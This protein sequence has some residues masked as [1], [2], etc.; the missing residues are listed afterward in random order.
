M[1]N[2]SLVNVTD[3]YDFPRVEAYRALNDACDGADSSYRNTTYYYDSD[4][5]AYGNSS[6]TLD[7]CFLP[8]SY[9]D[10]SNDCDDFNSSINPLGSEILCDGIDQDCSGA[11]LNG[12]DNDLD[13]YMVEGGYCGLVDCNDTNSSI[14]P[15]A[16]DVPCDGVDQDCSGADL[17]GTDADSDGYMVE[18][19]LCGAV[20][21]NDINV[22]INPDATEIACDG[23][24]QDCSGA[25]LNGTDNDLDG[26]M[27]EGGFCGL[28][29]CNDTNSSINPGVAES[30]CDGMDDNCDGNVDENLTTIYYYDFDNDTYGNATDY[31]DVCSI[32]SG[33]VSDNQDCNDA[34]DSVAPNASETLNG[35]DDNCNGFVDEG[36]VSGNATDIFSTTFTDINVTVNATDE[37]NQTFEGDVSVVINADNNTAVEFTFDFDNN[38]LN[39]SAI[40]IERQ[41]GNDSG[42]VIISGVNLSEQGGTKTVYLDDLNKSVSGVCIK[43]AE[44][45][46]ITEISDYCNGTNE[47]SIDCSSTGYTLNGYTCTDLGGRLKIEGLNNSGV[48]E[49]E[50]CTDI[51][52]DGYGVGCALGVDC[53]D[54]DESVNPGETEVCGDGIDNDCDGSDSAC[55]SSS[56]GGGGGGGGGASYAGNYSATGGSSETRYFVSIEPNKEVSM[57]IV[58]DELSVIKTSFKSKSAKEVVKLKV[59]KKDSLPSNVPSVDDV[60]EYIE[61]LTEGIEDSD[62]SEAKIEF[63]VSKSFVKDG[64]EVVLKRYESEWV[65][66]ETELIDSDSDY[67]Y[68]SA[69]TPGFSYFAISLKQAEV[70][71]EEV[72]DE[73]EDIVIEIGDQEV[74][75]TQESVED[76][77]PVV[78][79][80]VN[81]RKSLWFGLVIVLIAFLVIYEVSGGNK[82]LK[83]K[84]RKLFT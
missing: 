49:F 75:T 3:V 11:D 55:R 41:T 61:V 7:Y 15:G 5:D 45:S 21:C 13:G 65:D 20:D 40:V 9:I 53:D 31:L 51:D 24:D 44:I 81:D 74:F 59:A 56:S 10:N 14:N 8:W 83:K 18:G 66:L 60:H 22:S 64:Y 78:E 62:I 2:S 82:K 68:Y 30:V 48:K 26:Y 72:V 19:G 58:R 25:D 36:L 35:V 1:K 47:F 16:Y 4:L 69:V 6:V 80:P 33:Y 23:I 54:T 63:A 28:V 79:Q 29:D 46:S 27:L 37:L 34:L 39:L 17:N 32:P 67:F 57:D 52:G 84:N 70:V 77:E 50:A 71:I 73:V 43:D 76:L 42:S 12:T 38:Y